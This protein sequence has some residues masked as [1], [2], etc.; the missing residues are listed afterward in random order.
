MRRPGSASGRNVSEA[1]TALPR[2]QATVRSTS[3]LKTA[4]PSCF[5]P[6]AR[7][8]SSRETNSMRVCSDPRR[9]PAGE[10]SFAP[11]TRSSQS[12]NR[13][14]GPERSFTIFPAGKMV[15]DRS[16][17]DFLFPDC[18]ERVVG[19]NEHSPAGDRR[20]SEHTRIEFVS[21]EDIG[22]AS[23]RKHDGLAVFREEVD[24][25]VACNRGSAVDASDTF[26]PDA[27]PG[28]RI[29]NGSNADVTD[30]VNQPV[31]LHERRNVRRTGRDL[32]NHMAGFHVAFAARTDRHIRTAS[33]T[34]TQDDEAILMRRHRNWKAVRFV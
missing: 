3:S 32:P 20:G 2:L 8:I 23:G 7:P 16:G 5:R 30:H 13:K 14:S 29:D 1:S 19:A 27:L 28:L 18:E 34:A 9:S 11:T 24:L 31:V 22:R 6:D 26:L 21:R 15:N 12:G 25:T 33:V 4:R 17:P 10:C